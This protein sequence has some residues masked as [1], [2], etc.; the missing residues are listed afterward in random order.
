MTAAGRTPQTRNIALPDGSRVEFTIHPSARSKSVRL[1]LN[2]RHGLVVVAPAGLPDKQ[3]MDLVSA[4]ADWIAEKLAGFEDVRHLLTRSP[5][6]R[7]EAFD[8]PALAESW[9]VEYQQTKARTVGARTAEV[10]R[11]IVC[12]DVK[13]PRRCQAALR[14]WLAR[15][16]KEMLIPWL[17]RVSLQTGL[18]YA[19]AAIKSQRTRWG[20]CSRRHC[21][22]LNSKLLFLPPELVRYV[23]VHELSHTLEANHSNRFW[24]TV[25]GYEP[26]T[27]RLHPRMAEAWKRIP[28]WATA[29]SSRGC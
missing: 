27:D 6:S 9:R 29:E 12:G 3:T 8:L 28:Q 13:E 11:I 19:D 25:R 22:S 2:A 21:I 24:A 20:S 1:K 18:V 5:A 10:G 7:P 4:R 17:E 26:A 16:A 23:L 15:R 14:R